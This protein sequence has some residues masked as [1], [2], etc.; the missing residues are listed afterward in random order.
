MKLSKALYF[1]DF[2]AIPIAI[3]VLA[4]AA[5]SQRGWEAAS[6]WLF[7]FVAGLGVWTFVEYV[8]HLTFWETLRGLRRYQALQLGE[9]CFQ[10]MQQL[11]E[12]ALPPLVNV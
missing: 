4:G 9:I 1:G 10:M 6:L 7:A 11:C 5:V 12:H 2:V 3:V 8:V